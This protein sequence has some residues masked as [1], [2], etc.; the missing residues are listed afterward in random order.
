MR[1][2]TVSGLS[3]P[4]PQPNMGTLMEV[5]WGLIVGMVLAKVFSPVVM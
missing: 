3:P 5:G 4:S 1:C 2:S